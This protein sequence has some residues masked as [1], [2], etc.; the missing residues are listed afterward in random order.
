MSARLSWEF[1]EG[2][3]AEFRWMIAI[4][5]DLP[6]VVARRCGRN[7]HRW[8]QP[9]PEQAERS[10]APWQT[11]GFM[12]AYELEARPHEQRSHS[13]SVDCAD[14]RLVVFHQLYPG[15]SIRWRSAIK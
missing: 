11:S 2:M 15:V 1:P 10:S 12:F 4:G 5:S 3:W 9:G 14:E 13:P 7:G 8:V 6:A